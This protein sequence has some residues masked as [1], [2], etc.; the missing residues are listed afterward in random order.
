M[1]F[2]GGVSFVPFQE[3][4]EKLIPTAKMRYWETYNASE[5]FFGVQY[6]P[7]SKDMLL[8]LDN[9]VYYEFIPADEWGKENPE[10]VPLSGVETGKQYAMIISTSGGLWRYSIDDTIEFTS[11]VLSLSSY[12]QNKTVY[13]CLW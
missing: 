4:Y 5:G 3:Q 11:T 10:T 13:Q 2:H 7:D 8:L 12:R 6:T 1:F 9:E